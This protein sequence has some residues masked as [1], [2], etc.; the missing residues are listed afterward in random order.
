MNLGVSQCKN[1]WRWGY[2]THSCR[3][4]ESRYVKCSSPHKSKHYHQFGWCCKANSKTN[5]SHLETKKGEL[6]L[7][8][9]KCLNCHGDHQVDS[10]QCPFWKHRFNCDWHSKKQ[11]EICENRNKSIC[12]AISGNQA[13]FV[14]ISRFFLKMFTRTVSS[15]ISS[16]KH[17]QISISSSSRN[18]PRHIF[19]QSWVYSIVKVKN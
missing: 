6:C 10:D 4:Q 18:H 5:P 19:V 14:R 15:F 16:S 2:A 9:F 13:W 1:C 12:L 3:I 7:H 11:V 17:I 8:A